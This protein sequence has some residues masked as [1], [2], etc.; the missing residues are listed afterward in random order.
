LAEPAAERRRGA[1]QPLRALGPHPDGGAVALYKGRY[2]PYVSHDG[3][4][5]S[6]PRDADIETFSLEQAIPLLEARREKS[7]RRGRNATRPAA[8]KSAK[9]SKGKAAKPAAAA[10]RAAPSKRAAGAPKKKKASAARPAKK[11]PPRVV[12][13]SD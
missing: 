2:G 4:I 9:A 8:A 7:P 5:A 10:K 11:P 12:A 6:L 3:V 1:A 13:Q